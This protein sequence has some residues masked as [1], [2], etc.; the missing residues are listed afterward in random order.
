[1]SSPKTV[2]DLLAGFSPREKVVTLLT[3]GN[4]LAEHESLSAQLAAAM[5]Q[6]RTSL[7]D[8]SSM[9]GLAEQIAELEERIGASAV[10]FRLRGLGRN[11]FRRLLESHP[12]DGDPFDKDSFPPALI[13]ACA[14]DP[15][16]TAADTQA[17]GSVLTDGQYDEL[18][19]AAWAACREVDDVP[20]SALASAVTRGSGE[21]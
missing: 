4:L 7:A 10:T 20:F 15:P 3:G 17:L 21:R 12:S 16:L 13:T 1:L 14:V 6:T 9:Q 8:G 5:A 2:A 11:E 18:F 19:A